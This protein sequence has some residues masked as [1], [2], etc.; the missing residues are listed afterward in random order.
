MKIENH[1]LKR[2]LLVMEVIFIGSAVMDMLLWIGTAEFGGRHYVPSFT[3]S[4]M[5]IGIIL[6]L[7]VIRRE[8]LVKELTSRPQDDPPIAKK[9]IVADYE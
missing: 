7:E 6:L 5:C 1:I 4:G 9:T 2:V 8:V 3:I